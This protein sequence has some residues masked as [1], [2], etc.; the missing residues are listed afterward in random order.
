M[1]AY[2]ELAALATETEVNRQPA[3]LKRTPSVS[4]KN[5]Q[6]FMSCRGP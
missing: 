3:A 6:K 5:G 4:A 1:K 2:L